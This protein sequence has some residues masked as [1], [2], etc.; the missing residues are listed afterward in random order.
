MPL[1]KAEFL[2]LAQLVLLVAFLLMVEWKGRADEYALEKWLPSW[3]K[4]ALRWS[5]Y[6]FVWSAV[7]VFSTNEQ[8][9]I[10]FQF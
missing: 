3:S 1:A 2:R 10:Y 6:L 9:F 7:F 4:P 8:E 5:F